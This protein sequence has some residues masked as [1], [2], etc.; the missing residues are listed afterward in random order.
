[1][2]KHPINARFAKPL[3][4][5]LITD[6]AGNIKRI[7]TVE[8]NTI[9][10]GFGSG[11]VDFLQQLNL[12]DIQVKC[13]GLPD[14]FIE[15]GDQAALRSKYA[16]DTRGIIQDVLSLFPATSSDALLQTEDK[17]KATQF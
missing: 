16:S 11:V 4:T 8:E 6:L 14:A 17:A 10:G 2:R 9:S 7:V 5:E 1:M 15:Q 3:D 12:T 13:I